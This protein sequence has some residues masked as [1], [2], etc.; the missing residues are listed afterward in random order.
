MDLSD[1]FFIM[2]GIYKITSPTNKIYIGQSTNIYYRFKTYKRLNKSVK[3][4]PLL[5]NSLKKYGPENHKFE[6]LTECDKLELNNYERYYQ[7]LYNVIDKNNGLNCNLQKDDINP[8]IWSER[9]KKLLSNSKKGKFTGSEHHNC[10]IIVSV[11]LKTKETLEMGVYE[12]ARYFKVDWELIYNRAK[13]NQINLRKLKEWEFFYKDKI[14]DFKPFNF[15]QSIIFLD[16]ETGFYYYGLEDLSSAFN[17]KRS[18]MYKKLKKEYKNRI[19]KCLNHEI[20][21]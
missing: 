8:K 11:N 6:I 2:I 15:G 14:E 10:S 9:S 16:L 3:K 13:F 5:Y 7:E 12:T 17:I 21:K 19:K 20:T 4:Q 18:N 1:F